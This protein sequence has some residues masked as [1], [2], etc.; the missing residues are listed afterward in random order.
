MDQDPKQQRTKKTTKTAKTTTNTRR[1]KATVTSASSSRKTTKKQPT[2]AVTPT[3]PPRKKH[4]GLVI[5]IVV[6]FLLI[7]GFGGVLIWYFAYYNNPDKVVFEA[8]ENLIGAEHL[9]IRGGRVLATINS[10]QQKAVVQLKFD[11]SALDLPSA[12]NAELQISFYDSLNPNASVSQSITI[13]LG[14]VQMVDGTLYAKV[15]NLI[16]SIDSG[17]AS[18]GLT[19]ADLGPSA[20]LVYDFI[21]EIDGEWWQISYQD[22]FELAGAS[23]GQVQAYEDFYSCMVGVVNQ[24]HSVELKTLYNQHPFVKV[25]RVGALV[26]PTDESYGYIESN[27][28]YSYYEAGLDFDQLASFLNALPES[29]VAEQFYGCYN[30][31]VHT[32]YG[33]NYGGADGP[34]NAEMFDEISAN[35]LAQIIP[36]DYYIRLEISNFGHEVR[37]ILIGN[38]SLDFHLYLAFGY[39][40]AEV[41]AP[42]SYRPITDLVDDLGDLVQSIFGLELLDYDT[43]TDIEIDE[44]V[45][46]ES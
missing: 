40:T 43:L 34:M 17:L 3:P 21:E 42:D 25:A 32:V 23:Q 31:Y 28:G 19:I 8:M 11:T 30:D 7:F 16:D 26:S 2:L 37:N 14:T 12:M 10:S 44:R 36:N 45:V 1:R 29:Q 18:Q 5:L 41:S 35:E 6:M 15:S 46:W 9:S 20:Q 4:T 33:N 22:L 39:Q 27:A 38:P 24:S 13:D